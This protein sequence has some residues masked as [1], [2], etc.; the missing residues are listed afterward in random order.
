MWACARQALCCLIWLSKKRL[1]LNSIL[2]ITKLRPKQANRLPW[3]LFTLE[4]TLVTYSKV[5]SYIIAH[6][7]LWI[8]VLILQIKKLQIKDYIAKYSG[9]SVPELIHSENRLRSNLFE[10]RISFVTWETCDRSYRCRHE[11]L[12]GQES[13]TE[14]LFNNQDIFSMSNLVKNQIIRKP[15]PS[16][17]KV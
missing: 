10:S 17:T 12:L 15:R 3:V 11:R 6:G 2:Q 13:R 1:L 7:A 4:R 5:F 9:T 14:V 16:I 8:T